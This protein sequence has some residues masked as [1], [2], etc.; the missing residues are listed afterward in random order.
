MGGLV[1]FDKTDNAY[2]IKN[3]ILIDLLSIANI[4]NLYLKL[5]VI[6]QKNN[7]RVS[8]LPLSSLSQYTK[9]TILKANHNKSHEVSHNKQATMAAKQDCHSF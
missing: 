4:I 1:V 3:K 8:S 2:Y 7:K 5:I 6:L 9:G